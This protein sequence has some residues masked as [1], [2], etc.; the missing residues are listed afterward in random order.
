LNDLKKSY[1]SLQVQTNAVKSDLNQAEAVLR[2]LRD[3]EKKEKDEDTRRNIWLG[4]WFMA[5]LS[6]EE[7]E[8][9][10][11]RDVERRAAQRVRT[12]EVERLRARVT[13]L[14]SRLSNLN[15]SIAEKQSEISLARIRETA[16]QAAMKREE[17]ERKRAKMWEEQRAREAERERKQAEEAARKLREWAERRAREAERE[18]AEAERLF[19]EWERRQAREAERERKQ[20]EETDRRFREWVEA[21]VNEGAQGPQRK[22]RKK[23]QESQAC[24]HRGWW[25]RESGR[26]VCQECDSVMRRFAFRCPGC[27]MVAC[28][29]CRDDL[30][31]RAS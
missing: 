7:K 12:A 27:Q 26:A 28:A 29:S 9:R 3:E 16:R 4:Y 19:K 18:A 20:A 11:R 2:K 5:R 17:E 10:E 23:K 8:A 24:L 6:T 25:T 30:K 31:R 13:N 22:N 1:A 14:E 21:Q 15:K